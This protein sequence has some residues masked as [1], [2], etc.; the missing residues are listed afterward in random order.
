[1][2]ELR[3]SR[4]GYNVEGR[5]DACRV[6]DLI[7]ALGALILLAPIMIVIA[8]AIRLYDGGP[9]LFFHS[10]IGRGGFSFRCI[11]F[12]TM[13][14]DAQERLAE[15]LHSSDEA[16]AEWEATQ[17]LKDDPRITP[18]GRFLRRSS[19]DELPQFINVI[20]GEMAVVG[21]RPIVRSEV[22]RYGAAFDDYCRVPPGITG[23]WQISG[24]SDTDYDQRVALDVAYARTKGP[25]SDLAIIIKTVPAVLM[26][27]GSY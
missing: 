16:R 8:A 6:L 9:A 1:M 2:S 14:V 11:K 27:K 12:R 13:A 23:L 22:S 3:A 26:Q 21:P 10:R 18:I 4:S 20:L 5:L 19:L 15:L 7:V 17:K 25:C 24:R